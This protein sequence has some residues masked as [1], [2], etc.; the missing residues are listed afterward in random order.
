[1]QKKKIAKP[2]DPAQN[3]SAPP[4][5]SVADLRVSSVS[6][7]WQGPPILRA[8]TKKILKNIIKI[9]SRASSKQLTRSK[10]P[11]SGI[12]GGQTFT[13]FFFF[14]FFFFTFWNQRNLLPKWKFLLGKRHFTLGKNATEG[15]PPWAADRA[16]FLTSG[17]APCHENYGSTP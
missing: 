2:S 13:F 12:T 16:L 5:M 3:I 10:G 17:T 15:P 6:S 7:C 9:K 4:P 1:M 14:F 11:T 8:L